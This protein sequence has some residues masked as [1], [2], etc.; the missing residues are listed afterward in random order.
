MK[1]LCDEY[2]EKSGKDIMQVDTG[3]LGGLTLGEHLNIF[4]SSQGSEVFDGIYLEL[5]AE[6]ACNNVSSLVFNVCHP[7]GLWS[8]VSG[9]WSLVFGLWSLVRILRIL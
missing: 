7:T 3:N 4:E 1:N 9:L 8:L 5:D 6:D 2:K